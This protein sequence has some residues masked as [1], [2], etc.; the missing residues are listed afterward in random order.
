[1]GSEEAHRA[2]SDAF[3][4]NLLQS[5]GRDQ[6]REAEATIVAV[7][8]PDQ[9]D[10]VAVPAAA[11]NGKGINKDSWSTRTHGSEV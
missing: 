2:E 6:E 7:E 8:F 11:C 10:G 5:T 9:I 3:R 1:L 4:R